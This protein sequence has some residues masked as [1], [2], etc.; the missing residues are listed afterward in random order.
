MTTPACQ[1]SKTVMAGAGWGN[2]K[3][4]P[5]DR[6]VAFYREEGKGKK[7]LGEAYFCEAHTPPWRREEYRRVNPDGT[8]TEEEVKKEESAG[9]EDAESPAAVAPSAPTGDK[10][11]RSTK[12]KDKHPPCDCG[13]A[14]TGKVCDAKCARFQSQLR[15]A[16]ADRERAVKEIEEEKAER[17]ARREKTT[18][19]VQAQIDKDVDEA[20]GPSDDEKEKAR[21]ILSKVRKE[22][23]VPKGTRAAKRQES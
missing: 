16:E 19:S 20:L 6:P 17:R 11:K 5:C 8:F 12:K 21:A 4:E 15:A 7:A 10:P 3:T 22:R 18:A 23:R 1:F 2:V 13:A 9:A 14:G